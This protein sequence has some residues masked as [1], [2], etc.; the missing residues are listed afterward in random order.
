MLACCGFG[1]LSYSLGDMTKD[2]FSNRPIVEYELLWTL[3][4]ACLRTF[5][6]RCYLSDV[7]RSFFE[8]LK[9]V[10]NR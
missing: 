1:I 10:E 2:F 4:L 9:V 6:Y 5:L 8:L 3:K 7:I